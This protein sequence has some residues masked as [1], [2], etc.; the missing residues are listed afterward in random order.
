M[1]ENESK[2]KKKPWP[3]KDVMVQIY[4]KKLWGDHNSK[5]Y[6]GVGSHLPEIVEPYVA[7]V[8]KFLMSFEKP[9]VV[10]D[11]G[12]GDFNVGKELVP[13]T[14]KF[15]GIDIVPALIR[16]NQKKFKGENLELLE[17]KH[18]I[19][20]EHVPQG[21]VDW[22]KDI[23]AGQGIRL[24]K[25]SG[26]NIVAPPFNFK[27]KEAKELVFIPLNEGKEALITTYYR[28]F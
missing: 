13:Y 26:L 2:K 6:S 12:C 14:E 17:F 5:F 23:I 24:K 9:L 1:N 8:R 18:I 11:V 20:T 10:C 19:V 15:I 25:H 21:D 27:V 3:T 16:Y 28:A 22:N 7:A 4:E